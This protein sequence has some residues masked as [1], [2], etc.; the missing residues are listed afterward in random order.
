MK[1]VMGCSKLKMEFSVFSLGGI[2]GISSPLPT[3]NPANDCKEVN[4]KSIKIESFIFKPR[5]CNKNQFILSPTTLKVGT[6]ECSVHKFEFFYL[7]QELLIVFCGIFL[8][9]FI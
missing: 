5:F 1:I 8:I 9:K 6:I 4:R 3:S 7:L 2:A